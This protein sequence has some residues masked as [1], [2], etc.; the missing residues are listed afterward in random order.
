MRGADALMRVLGSR[1]TVETLHRALQAADATVV[2]SLSRLISTDVRFVRTSRYTWGLRGWGLDEYDGVVSAI[3]QR[4]DAA[5]GAAP[6]AA[7]VADI[8]AHY[9]DVAE[10]SIRTYLST[11]AF[12]VEKGVARRRTDDDEW[13]P[14]APLRTVRGCYRNGPNEIR[15]VLAVDHDMLRGSGRPIPQPVADA[16]GVSPGQ[17]RTFSGPGG[18]LTVVWRLSSTTG[19]SVG[20]LRT[21]AA[22]VAVKQGDELVLSLR[23]DDASFDITRTDR[24]E[25]LPARLSKLLGREVHDRWDRELAAGLDCIPAQ[26]EDVL[27]TRGDQELLTLLESDAL[28]RC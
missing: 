22:A 7:I 6:V 1:V 14:V 18:Q 9:P 26:V 19:A 27:R 5:G 25:T 3:G 28:A 11:L 13:P 24:K 15:L 12:V 23:T 20:S 17:R 10:S 16:V 8:L 4:I 21:Q 2:S